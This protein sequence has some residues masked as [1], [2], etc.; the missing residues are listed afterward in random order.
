MK[1]HIK[2]FLLTTKYVKIISVNPLYFAFSKAN[3][4]LE[5]TN[6]KKCLMLVSTNEIRKRIK[7]NNEELWSKT[8]NLIISITKNEMIL[9]KNI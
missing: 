8:I 2:I 1:N 4:C 6:E 9:M 5:E 7:Q 3:R